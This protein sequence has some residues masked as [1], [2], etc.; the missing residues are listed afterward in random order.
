MSTDLAKQILKGDVRAAA[1]VLTLVENRDPRARAILK[2]IYPQTGKAHIIGMT[3]AAGTGKSVLIDRMTAELRG[4][5]KKVGILTVDPT[6]PFSGGALLGDRI[7]MRD[8]FL[9]EGVFIRSMATRGG[10]GGVSAAVRDSVH[11]LD[12]AGKEIVFIETIGVGQ[13]EVE[14]STIA[15]T[16]VVVLAPWMGDEIQGMKAGLL[17]ISDLLVVSKADLPG[18]E[19]TFQCLRRLFE[20][21]GLPILKTSA[22]TNEGIDLLLEGIERHRAQLLASGDQWRRNLNFSRRQLLSLVRARILAQA[23]PKIDEAFIEK[24]VERIAERGLDPYTAAEEVVR[25]AGI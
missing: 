8:H 16:V 10:S 22:I 19:E 25:K 2:A 1:Q 5:K 17:E 9:D 23:L 21:S 20:D 24:L 18:A 4:R 7:R 13:D 11:L 3:G 6:S 14:V 15:H 12:A